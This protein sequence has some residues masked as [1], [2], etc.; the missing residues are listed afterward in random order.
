M[1]SGMAGFSDRILEW[2]AING[3]KLPWRGNTDPYAVWVSEIMLQQT[4]VETV[5]PY[6]DRW[7]KQ[8]PTVW[9]LAASNEQEVL[10]LWEGLGYYS[11]ARKLFKAAGIVIRDYRG[12]LPPDLTSLRSLPG[13]GPYTAGAI[14]SIAF[15]MDTATLDGNQKRIFARVFNINE[16]A[17][18]PKGEKIL[19][20][21]AERTLPKG[22]AGDYNQALMDL[23][24]MICLPRK[25]LCMICPVKKSCQAQAL[26]LQE[27]RPVL[28]SKGTVPHYTVTAA[29]MKKRG[30]ILLAKRPAEGLLGGMWEFPGGKVENDE[31]LETCLVREIQEELGV[32]IHVGEAFGIYRHAYTHFRIT[33]HAF[34]CSVKKGDPKPIKATELVWVLPEELGNYPMGKVDRQIAKQLI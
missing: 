2:Y 7:M 27:Q 9:E 16:S 18:E 34:L 14:A 21:I 13:I 3:R 31:E 17:N 5:I 26:G 11:R 22:Q 28:R 30:R 10:S 4:R 24:S 32:S 33:L 8:Y 1:E 29:V 12:E 6:F 23:G 25:P 20:G 19:W 15:G